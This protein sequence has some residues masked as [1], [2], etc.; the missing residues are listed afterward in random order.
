MKKIMVT[1]LLI[2]VLIAL[3]C[4]TGKAQVIDEPVQVNIDGVFFHRV[5]QFEVY[6]L[7]ESQREGN[8][9]ILVNADEAVLERYIPQ[10]GFMH[11]A[12][13][14]LVKTPGQNILVDTGTGSGGVIVDKIKR[15]G[16]EP[17]KVDT[18]LITH[19][20]MDHFGGLQREGVANF[21]N[22]RIYVSE[23]DHE[24][25]TKTSVNQNAV[26]ALNLYGNRVTTFAPGTLGSNLTA[27]LPGF[28]PIANYGHTPGHTVFLVENGSGKLIIA[29]DF[30]HLALVQFPVPDIS[31]TFD[32]DKEAAAV[33]RRQ[34]LNYAARNR[35]PIGGMHIVY[36]GIGNV[37]ADGNGFRF[38]PLK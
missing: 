37:E 2:G 7:V 27:L 9:G 6:M 20:H 29:A 31:A 12:N 11:T 32:V 38:T 34:I 26:T 18:V 5:G 30:L 21:P 35:I 1:G 16:V 3:G 13:A 15:L 24:F 36:P 17:D 33:S 10:T 25:F 19:L 4:G 8:T 14:F 22:A 28:T 23:K